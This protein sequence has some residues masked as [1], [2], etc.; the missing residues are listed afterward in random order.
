MYAGRTH[1]HCAK[2]SAPSFCCW[3]TSTHAEILLLDRK[4][5]KDRFHVRPTLCERCGR[6]EL[7]RILVL[8][9]QLHPSHVVETSELAARLPVHPHLGEAHSGVK[10]DTAVIRHRHPCQYLAVALVAEAAEQ[11]SVEGTAH[12]PAQCGRIDVDRRFNGPLVSAAG[13]IRR[14][15]GVSDHA[16]IGSLGDHPWVRGEGRLNAGSN[17]LCR[18]HLSLE[19]GCALLDG[20]A[21]DG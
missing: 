6:C 3:V 1:M 8:Q 2:A 12:S 9:L 16:S 17:R 5:P 21:V 15:V 14:T 10:T 11:C 4:L 19:G 13:A 7:G 20:W 18:W